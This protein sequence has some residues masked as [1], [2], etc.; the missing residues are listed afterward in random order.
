MY[1][2][3]N[4]NSSLRKSLVWGAVTGGSIVMTIC[5]IS[6]YGLMRYGLEKHFD[7]S[8]VERLESIPDISGYLRH[9]E[10]DVNLFVNKIEEMGVRPFRTADLV[11]VRPLIEVKN[12]N[13]QT[14][15]RSKYLLNDDAHLVFPDKLGTV[16]WMRLKDQ[17][18]RVVSRKVD[19]VERFIT[20]MLP[21]KKRPKDP[22]DPIVIAE[23][24]KRDNALVTEL[25]EE[26]TSAPRFSEGLKQQPSVIVALARPAEDLNETLRQMAV[27][28]GIVYVVSLIAMAVTLHRIVLQQLR[29]LSVL[30]EEIDRVDSDQMGHRIA[31]PLP[32]EL[33]P[34]ADRLNEL[35]DQLST[36]MARERAFSSDLAHEF[37]T[38]LAGIRA[39]IDLAR[40]RD[41]QAENYRQTLDDCLTISREMEATVESMLTLARL[42]GGK[43]RLGQREI[44]LRSAIERVWRDFKA[45]AKA[46][47]T[48]IHHQIQA[49]MTLHTDPTLLRIIL[50]NLL[51]NAVVH[52]G[53]KDVIRI[54][55]ATSDEGRRIAITNGG[56]SLT[57]AEAERACERFWRG[58]SA[59]P[60]PGRHCGL[61]LSLVRQSV[62]L[63]GGQLAIASERGGEFRV[64][65]IFSNEQKDA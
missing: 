46:Q 9:P 22:Y 64:E 65:L 49:G 15:F 11:E 52:S 44:P 8:M 57:Q 40:S 32:E 34:A 60:T 30:A 43:L 7:I 50:R 20:D 24:M 59:R 47:G 6:A 56:S 19:L 12:L 55:G 45:Q 33:R 35:L 18:F 42:E 26:I 29:P 41:R 48:T 37:K 13:G 36:S 51:E 4:P 21:R 10:Q 53:N 25:K 3:R 16:R 38:P 27:V 58:D 23:V 1:S 31:R 62:K 28:L 14:L 54:E 5:L 63:L 17:H 61:G 39:K 2:N